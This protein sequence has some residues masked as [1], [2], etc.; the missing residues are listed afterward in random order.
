MHRLLIDYHLNDIIQEENF[1]TY[2][3]LIKDYK[4]S[5]NNIMN[6]IQKY[7]KSLIADIENDFI[8]EINYKILDEK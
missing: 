5:V 1:D 4:N 6:S 7:S 3:K 2:N 8:S